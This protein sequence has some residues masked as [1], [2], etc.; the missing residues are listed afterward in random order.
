MDLREER[1]NQLVV[2]H[3]LPSDIVGRCVAADGIVDNEKLGLALA[4]RAFAQSG[5]ANANQA[6]I[7]RLTEE[8][9]VAQDKRDPA[10][11][12]RLQSRIFEL[13]GRMTARKKS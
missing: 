11:M 6:E 13:G 5:V 2:E 7:E 3:N 4:T 9:Y 1:I 8:Y 10:Q 12:I